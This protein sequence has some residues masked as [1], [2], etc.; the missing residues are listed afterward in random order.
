MRSDKT[1]PAVAKFV[2]RRGDTAALGVPGQDNGI[3][4]V[5]ESRD[6]SPLL[7]KDPLVLKNLT[8]IGPHAKIPIN[9]DNGILVVFDLGALLIAF[10]ICIGAGWQQTVTR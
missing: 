2:Q 7:E 3:F 4:A 5:I 9:L 10:R 6:D 1:N 8:S